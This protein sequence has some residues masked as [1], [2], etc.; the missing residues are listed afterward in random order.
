MELNT[1]LY[2]I[3]GWTNH[4][5][6]V[7]NGLNTKCLYKY[8]IYNT[9][10]FTSTHYAIGIIFAIKMETIFDVLYYLN[11]LEFTDKVNDDHLENL[12]CVKITLAREFED[13]NLDKLTQILCL[14]DRFMVLT[15]TGTLN[16]VLDSTY[17]L[18]ENI[19][20][21]INLEIL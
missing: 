15:T 3:I 21:L 1:V 11:K 18:S 10:N 9:F 20:H 6:V 17:T 4:Q 12:R 13:Y 2:P 7:V 14:V 8:I 16:D 19:F 5:I